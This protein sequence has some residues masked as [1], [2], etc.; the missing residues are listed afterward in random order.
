MA[1]TP[2]DNEAFFRE[3][4][5][6]V[7]EQQLIDLW[8]RHGR[9]IIA[10]VVLVL[11]VAAGVLFW[12]AQQRDQAEAHAE[13]LAGM[14]A[15]LDDGKTVAPAQLVPLGKARRDGYRVAAKFLA[16]DLALRRNDAKSAI[17]GYGALATDAGLPQPYRD[18][19]LI[20]QT[21]VEFD[22]LPPATIIARMKPLAVAGGPWLGSAGEMLAAAYMRDGKPALA[23]P[24][25]AM[26]AKD[27][28]APSTLRS[29]AGQMASMLGTDAGQVPAA[30]D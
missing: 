13:Q 22:Q 15:D 16:A 14:L 18:L 28:N 5:E 8:E 26:I 4:D 30:K 11:V 21:A 3:V 24:V 23:A 1:L 19:A 17:A 9:A 7:R 29:R 2:Q 20:R 10:A 27:E 6:R 12:Q 25:F